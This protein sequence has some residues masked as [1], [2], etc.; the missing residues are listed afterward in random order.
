MKG[1]TLALVIIALLVNAPRFV[2]VFLRADSLELGK[3]FEAGL[4]IL[5][6]IAT[7]CVLSGGGAVIAH[8]LAKHKHGGRWRQ[9]LAAIWLAMLAFSVVLIAPLMVAGIRSSDLAK[10]LDT[11]AWQWGWAIVAVLAVEVLAAGAMIANALADEPIAQ[12][13]EQPVALPARIEAPQEQPL[14]SW[15]QGAAVVEQPQEQ[16]GVRCPV[17]NEWCK[18]SKALNAHSKKHINESKRGLAIGFA[19]SGD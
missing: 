11:N 1:V 10:V 13:Q 12:Q 6:A 5:T 2:L 3:Q 15:L 7:G 16:P 8:T 19:P 4:L 9:A 18:S 14:A 17:C